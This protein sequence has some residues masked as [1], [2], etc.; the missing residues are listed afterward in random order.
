M[1]QRQSARQ[2]NRGSERNDPRA[3]PADRQSQRSMGSESRR[4]RS[5]R[6]SA[7]GGKVLM[8][9]LGVTGLLLIVCIV[10]WV[11]KSGEKRVY[12]KGKQEKEYAKEQNIDRAYSAFKLAERA[13]LNYVMGRDAAAKDEVLFGTLRGKENIYNIIFYRRFKDM[14]LKE[15]LEEKYLDPSRVKA[16]GTLALLAEKEGIKINEG[17]AEDDKMPIVIAQKSYPAET[18]DKINAGGEI[19][20]IVKA[21][22]E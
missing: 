20:V 13:G 18:G 6:A 21:F 14:K 10:L 5:T 9:C 16:V 12:E 22:K 17:V 3:G 4:S 1:A 7:G 15:K 2:P 11:Q 8:I 19:L